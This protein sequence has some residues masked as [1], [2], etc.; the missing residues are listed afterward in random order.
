MA[1]PANTVTSLVSVGNREDLEDVIYR[2]APEETP[3]VNNIGSAKATATYHEWQTEALATAVASNAN[4]EGN[5]F[6]IAAGNLTTRVGNTCQILTKAFGVSRTEDVV[7]KAGR[8]SE[9]NRQKVL[10][11]IECRRDFEMSCIANQGA[12]AQSGGT[13]R[14][15]GGALAW[16][17][18]NTSV[19]AGGA[20]GG[21]SASPGPTAATNGTQRTITEALVKTVMASAFQ[22]GGKPS[23]AYLSPVDK[24]TFSTFTGIAD[25]RV[26]AAGNKMAQIVGAADVYVSDFGNLALIPHPYALTRDCLLITPDMFAV[27][28]L[29]GWK[30]T[31]LAQVSDSDQ[32]AITYEATLVCRNEK[33]HGV[34]RD[35]L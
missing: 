22:A 19:G 25:I 11:G 30:S 14:S 35:L 21:F 1:A 8:T 33:A 34:I 23:Q 16:L 18:T 26:N 20:N 15:L 12:V 7:K 29:D 4:L 24:Q 2:V 31:E 17:V 13:P 5:T 10:K 3:F 32:Y 27:G 6:A 9:T 28:A